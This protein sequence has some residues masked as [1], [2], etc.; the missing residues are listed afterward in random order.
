MWKSRE[1]KNKVMREDKWVYVL[2]LQCPG[3]ISGNTSSDRTCHNKIQSDS[4]DTTLY[5]NIFLKHSLLSL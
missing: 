3:Q 2:V 1:G 4:L 5:T